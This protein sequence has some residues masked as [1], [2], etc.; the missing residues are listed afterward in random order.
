[1]LSS[2]IW[3]EIAVAKSC[4]DELAKAGLPCMRYVL[5]TVKH[6]TLH[7]FV[8][9]PQVTD[10]QGWVQEDDERTFQL[11]SQMEMTVSREWG[12]EWVKASC[13]ICSSISAFVQVE[14]R[15]ADRSV[16]PIAVRCPECGLRIGQNDRYLAQL[17]IGDLEAETKAKLL[18]GF[19]L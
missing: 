18:S 12:D 8:Q 17:H 3:R 11:S 2:S 13:R 19:G 9:W 1:L 16:I 6:K 14:I 10:S 15:E 7:T 5:K 4:C